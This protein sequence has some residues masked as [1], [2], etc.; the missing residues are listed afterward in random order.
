MHIYGRVPK[1]SGG[2]STPEIGSLGP[3]VWS[4]VPEFELVLDRFSVILLE[5]L[6]IISIEH[7]RHSW[8]F[9]TQRQ[10]E[11]ACSAFWRASGH[12]LVSSYDQKAIITE[13]ARFVWFVTRKQESAR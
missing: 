5:G 13:K 6:E 1:N 11:C 8:C 2:L 9:T 10:N 4:G 7:A 12:F 3:P